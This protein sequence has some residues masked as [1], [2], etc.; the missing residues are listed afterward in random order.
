MRMVVRTRPVR[1]TKIT[2]PP[3][4]PAGTPTTATS[5]STLLLE[6]LDRGEPGRGGAARVMLMIKGGSAAGQGK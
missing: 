1:V 3:G 6:G 5:T 4:S 2:V